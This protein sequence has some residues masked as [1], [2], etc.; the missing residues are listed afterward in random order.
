MAEEEAAASSDPPALYERTPV[1]ESAAAAPAAKPAAAPAAGKAEAAAA[2]PAA[3][4]A[5]A[6]A[7][8][9]ATKAKGVESLGEAEHPPSPSKIKS[10]EPW[11]Q[12]TFRTPKGRIITAQE[13]CQVRRRSGHSAALA[14]TS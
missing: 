2:K 1:P 13:L 10:H 6:A 12:G 7:S 9:K 3:A 14:G 5:P 4:A 11:L 8:K